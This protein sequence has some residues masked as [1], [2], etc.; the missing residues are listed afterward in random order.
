M[1]I[2]E[3][4]QSNMEI[5]Y[6][7]IKS[8]WDGYG[9]WLLNLIST[10]K[11]ARVLEIG[12]GAKPSI[13]LSAIRN[14]GIQEYAVLDISEKE[15]NKAP[16]GYTKICGDIC[17]DPIVVSGGYNLVISRMLAEH[18][19]SASRFH[20]NV[21]ALLAPGGSAFHFFP[22]LFCPVY[23]ANRLLPERLTW[24]L[25]NFASDDRTRE[26]NNGKFPAYYKWCYGP[27]R[28]QIR[29]FRNIG[30]DV[31]TYFGFFGHG[32]YD[33]IPGL[34]QIHRL[35]TRFLLLHPCPYFTTTAYLV[36]RK[37]ES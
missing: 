2:A 31:E 30:Y 32:Y 20:A 25:L 13:P 28:W 22:T 14:F 5:L 10:K 34:R 27:T 21:L 8:A 19:T 35:I 23:V 12:G 18:V 29:R 33:R 11:P 9:D 6:G 36:L 3:T 1:T 26:G 17:N 15:L 37:P 24:K 7:H 16:A 4:V